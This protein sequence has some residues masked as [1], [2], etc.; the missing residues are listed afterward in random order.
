MTTRRPSRRRRAAPRRPVRLAPQ[1]QRP[2]HR[3]PRD[4]HARASSP[5]GGSPATPRSSVGCDDL[6]RHGPRGGRRRGEGPAPRPG[7]LRPVPRH[8]GEAVPGVEARAGLGRHDGHA[9]LPLPAGGAHRRPQGLRRLPRHRPP[10]AGRPE[11][12]LQGVRA[13][14]RRREL[15]L[16]PHPP[17]LLG[18]GGPRAAG[19]QELPHGLRPRPVG[20]VRRLQARRPPRAREAGRA[21]RHRVRPHLPDL[22]HAERGPRRHDRLGVPGGA[23]AAPRGPT[24]EGRPDHDPEGARRPRPL[25]QAHHLPRGGEGGQGGAPHRARSGRRSATG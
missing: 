19:V 3:V 5:T 20:D 16:L 25:G 8:A 15:R 7:H 21:A 9:H 4:E 12:H 24:V 13:R 17:H 22:P 14:L 2:L 6:P 18:E 10:G 1:G 11:G 23:A